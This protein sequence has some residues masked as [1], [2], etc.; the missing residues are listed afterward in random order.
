MANQVFECTFSGNL[1]G[2]FVQTVL[3][4]HGD[5][6]PGYNIFQESINLAHSLSDTCMQTFLDSLPSD[7]TSTSIRVKGVMGLLGPTAILL[8][9]AYTC[10]NDTGARAGLIS[11]AQV[12]PLI[13]WIGTTTPSNTG[14][15]FM[16]GV[17]E[18]DIDGMVLTNAIITQY[19]LFAADIVNDVATG[20]GWDRHGVIFTRPRLTPVVIPAAYDLMQAFQV[21]P[22][23]GTQ[24]RRLHPV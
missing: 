11:S 19:G 16:P 3:C 24:R 4:F 6:T 17:S 8:P 13:T 12:N 18:D 2:Q 10:G 20:F 21:S 5:I 15:T 14:R 22:L 7:Y 9:G 1:H 23:I